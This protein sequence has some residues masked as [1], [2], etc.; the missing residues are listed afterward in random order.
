MTQC[1]VPGVILAIAGAGLSIRF[2]EDTRSAPLDRHARTVALSWLKDFVE[3]NGGRR[4]G[5]ATDRRPWRASFI[6]RKILF[7]VPFPV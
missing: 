1:P 2:E 4:A 5:L 7:S 3:M 6:G